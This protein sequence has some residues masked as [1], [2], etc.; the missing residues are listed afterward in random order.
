MNWRKTALTNEILELI[1]NK[2]K[3][4]VYVQSK[5]GVNGHS[6]NIIDVQ[7]SLP[8]HIR[9]FCVVFGEKKL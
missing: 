1:G 5:L 4:I 3:T 7:R 8:T 9:Q 6:S 2:S